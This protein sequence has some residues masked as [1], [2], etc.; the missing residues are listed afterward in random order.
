[1]AKI[2]KAVKDFFVN[3]LP[4]RGT[5]C[6]K[7][8]ADTACWGVE[9]AKGEFKRLYFKFP[10][11]EDDEI[12]IKV[13]YSG[14]CHSDCSKADGAWIMNMAYPLVP[15]HEVIGE[16]VMK[17]KKVTRFSLG[18]T[19]AVGVYRNFC[20]ECEQCKKGRDNLCEK[21]P[22]I[23]T[24]DPYLGGYASHMQ[25][26]ETFAFKIPKSLPLDRASPLLCAGVTVYAALKRWQKPGA[27]CGIV[28]IG[29]LGHLAIQFAY[30]MGMIPVAISSTP[31]KEPYCYQLG[32]KEFVYSEKESE[33]EHL[34]KT[35]KCDI[36]LNTAYV[37]DLTKYLYVLKNG[38]TF[39]QTGIPD[40]G[41]QVKFDHIDLVSNEKLFVGT[42]AGSRIDVEDTLNFCSKFDVLPIVE[43]Y[44]WKDLPKAYG[45]LHD[46]RPKFRC[47]IDV[48]S[49]FDDKFAK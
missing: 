19:V 2:V 3:D 14:L 42:M 15:G 13:L 12:R 36:I 27:R 39:I 1:M 29:G 20:G 37:H 21:F 6:D 34:K 33:M 10:E 4:N 26:R 32:A 16:I 30:K 31:G 23:L 46:E 40:T 11:L 48:D 24:Y 9:K 49:T 25:I 38:G 17:G 45:K 41:P 22:L 47:V 44:N 7:E 43:K 18:E 5:L 28:G 8:S 35:A